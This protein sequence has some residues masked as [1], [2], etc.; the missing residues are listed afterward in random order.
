V[1]FRF[2]ESDQRR[3]KFFKVKEAI[4]I[5]RH[6]YDAH[7][8][9][10]AMTKLIELVVAVGQQKK[11]RR[12]T[13]DFELVRISEIFDDLIVKV[14]DW[15]RKTPTGPWPHFDKFHTQLF[16]KMRA[17]PHKKGPLKQKFGLLNKRREKASKQD[18]HS[19]VL[20]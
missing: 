20:L 11:R 4:S 17:D 1:I 18:Q 10:Q 6:K 7:E 8:Q 9:Q 19:G 3:D 15:I 14:L 12:Q 13:K 16:N 5:Y 2:S